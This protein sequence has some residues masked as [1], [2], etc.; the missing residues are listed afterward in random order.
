VRTTAAAVIVVGV[1]LVVSAVA[2][3]VLLRRS[4]TSDVRAAALLRAEAVADDFAQGREESPIVVGDEEEEFVQVLDADGEVVAVSENLFGY[5]AIAVGPGET[6][7]IEGVPFEDDPF[8]TVAISAPSLDGSLTVISGATLESVA[9]ST[10]AVTGIIVVGIP[11]LLLL[12]G[13][14][15]WRVIGRTLGPVE[16][17]RA[18][19]EAI[20]AQELHR[21]VPDPAGNDEIA[22]LAA[23]MNRMLARLETGQAR[24]RRF[25]SDASHE[26]RSPIASIRQH[27]EVALSH[28]NEAG[29]QELAEVVLEENLR[30]QRLVEDLLLLT[31]VDE[32]N[33]RLRADPVDL[34]DIVFAEAERARTTNDLRID[35]AAVSAGRVSGDP[36]QLERLIRNLLDN[37]TRHARET[38]ALSLRD[39]DGE[40]VLTVDDDGAGIRVADRE[41]VFE[42]FVRLEEARDRDSGGSGLGLAIVAEIAAAQ[43]AT[44]AVLEGPLGGARLQVRFPTPRGERLSGSFS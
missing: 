40:V 31:K 12:L 25:V 7:E 13:A 23:T 16:G 43:G 32:G 21:R 2:M 37:A 20:S 4:L 28:P 15:M 24:Q 17:I 19:V 18:E 3:V 5:R 8:L 29:I 34:D 10:E 41:R 6:R 35:T 39:G 30:L 27:A 22:R 42:R 38:V 14:V 1:V 44:V 11:L 9:E 36:E 26:L 33:L